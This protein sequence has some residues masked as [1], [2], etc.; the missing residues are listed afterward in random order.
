MPVARTCEIGMVQVFVKWVQSV[1]KPKYHD[2]ISQVKTLEIVSHGGYRWQVQQAVI[3]EV[4]AM[5]TQIEVSNEAFEALIDDSSN[6]LPSRHAHVSFRDSWGGLDS[7]KIQAMFEH[8]HGAFR[9]HAPPLI[10]GVAGD[11]GDSDEE[12]FADILDSVFL[13]PLHIPRA[14]R[15]P[16]PQSQTAASTFG[17]QPGSAIYESL[18]FKVVAPLA[19]AQ[20]EV[21][22]PRQQH[23]QLLMVVAGQLG[24]QAQ[25][26][27][28][29]APTGAN[30]ASNKCCSA[31]PEPGAIIVPL[32]PCDAV[33]AEIT[34]LSESEAKGALSIST[35]ILAMGVHHV[36]FSLL[37]SAIG[38]RH[39][40]LSLIV[41]MARTCYMFPTIKKHQGGYK[42]AAAINLAYNIIFKIA[43]LTRR[44]FPIVALCFILHYTPPGGAIP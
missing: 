34:Q 26:H 7:D 6:D 42:S 14:R 39:P 10:V 11:N 2:R 35:Y 36:W 8:S 44:P 17:N 37:R 27:G 3:S 32:P 21:R 9:Q 25:E 5:S 16:V 29:S 43:V 38:F 41:T 19:G 15:V 28:K 18:V 23:D 40:N 30:T 12:H 31:G 33:P 22:S 13:H 4:N 24:I 20:E 1:K